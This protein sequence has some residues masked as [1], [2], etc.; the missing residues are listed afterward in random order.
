MLKSLSIF[1]KDIQTELIDI[2][3]ALFPYD[4]VCKKS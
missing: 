2:G 4:A 3:N 1:L